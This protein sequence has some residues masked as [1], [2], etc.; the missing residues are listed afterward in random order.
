MFLGD[1]R[2]DTCFICQGDME[3]RLTTFS[4]EVNNTVI[5]VKNV[6]SLVCTQC[7]DVSY[8]SQVAHRLEQIV[9]HMKDMLTEIAV[10]NYTVDIPAA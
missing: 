2:M 7:G 6:P 3:E 10:V 5:I 1:G 8:S 4:V 9:Q